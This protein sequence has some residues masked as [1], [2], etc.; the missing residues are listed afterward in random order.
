MRGLVSPGHT[1]EERNA[2]KRR[3]LSELVF[4]IRRGFWCAHTLTDGNGGA[5]S[6]FTPWRHVDAGMRKHRWCPQC[7]RF[8]WA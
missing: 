8:E 4:R 5:W 1:G 2:V 3:Q 7:R 6:T